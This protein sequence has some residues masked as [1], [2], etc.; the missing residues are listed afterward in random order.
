M[1]IP[2]LED[3][4]RSLEHSIGVFT[5]CL[6]GSTFV[7]SLGLILEYW[8][9]VS[10]FINELK[11]PM[12]IFR[13]P[14][15]MEI[16][17]GI[18]VTIGVLGEF[19]FTLEVFVLEGRLEQANHAIRDTL[20][21]KL[22]EADQ[23]AKTAISD[24]STALS[25]AKDALTKARKAAD[26]LGKA[27]DEANKAQ[28]AS[29]NALTLA[30]GARQEADSFEKD[31]SS[32]KKLATD[33]EAHLAD[34]MNRANTLTA[35]LNRITTPRSLPTSPE[36]IS[37]LK[38][39]KDTEYMFTGVCGD[40]ECIKLLRDIDKVLGLAEWK[41]VKAPHTFPGLVLWGKRED[42]DGT[43]F[44][45]EPGTKVSADSVQ[46]AEELGKLPLVSFPQHVRAAVALNL[47]LA[48]NVS[49]TENTGRLV[50][51]KMGTSTV[52]RVSVGRKP[53]P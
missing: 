52:V 17:G 43:G 13:W 16:A 14:K 24:S 27:E 49:P 47:A 38:A 6:L 30:R 36:L 35:Q 34:A 50:D 29:S 18:L 9:P 40:T 33:A 41:R 51:M 7:V 23:K 11:W 4:V 15:F 31:I 28:A 44:D 8:H 25:Q 48:S 12:S 5:W 26:S 21:A 1:D 53:L 46:G 32:A 45:F 3:A 39:F 37:S 20:T 2:A 22:G 10:E 42:D 19:G